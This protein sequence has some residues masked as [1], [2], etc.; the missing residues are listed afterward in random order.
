MKYIFPF[1]LILGFSACSP[2]NVTEDP[3]IDTLYKQYG[4]TGNFGLFDNG[5]GKFLLY[6]KS[7]F[8]DS[9]YVPASTFKVF[10]SLVAIETGRVNNEKEVFPYTGNP[11]K[12]EAWNRDMTFAEALQTSSEPVYREVAGRIGRDT[13]QHWIDTIGYAQRYGKPKIVSAP[14]CWH[15]G[16]LKVTGDE[17]LGLMKTFYFD[18]LPLQKR[19][20]RTVRSMMLTETT[21]AYQLSYK[22]GLHVYPSGQAS[23][24]I[25]GWVEENKHPYF[26]SLYVQGPSE[27]T[28]VDNRLQLLKDILKKQGFLEG[29]R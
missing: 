18:Q 19:S 22:T 3:S 2:N 27:K 11:S 7:A 6:N 8:K 20:Q 23:G 14:D 29:K 25:I 24:W 9:A 26:F 4:L 10:L 15:D 5:Q 16:T 12:M 13:L 21:T 17:Q 28:I 1:L